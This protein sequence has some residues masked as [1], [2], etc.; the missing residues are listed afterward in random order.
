MNK[1]VVVTGSRK[2]FGFSL[3]REFAKKG[4]NVVMNSRNLKELNKSKKLIIDEYPKS[5]VICVQSDISQPKSCAKI[6]NNAIK[7]FGKIDYWINNAATLLYK[8]DDFYKLSESEISTI[9]NTNFTGMCYGTREAINAMSYHGGE[10]YNI[11]GSGSF[12]EVIDG[13]T[14]YS[15][16][17][18]PL[19]YFSK[20]AN[21]EAKHKNIHVHTINPGIIH[22]DLLHNNSN[23]PLFVKKYLT[24]TPEHIAEYVVA[25]IENRKNP[26]DIDFFSID[27]L[28]RT[29]LK[30]SLNPYEI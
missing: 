12:G 26:K 8:Y 1:T 29:V 23:I 6:A 3:S 15:S 21:L 13:Y 9:I 7:A 22:T 20:C 28:V 5:K 2:G 10:I 16:S 27:C 17:K 24:N 25:C 30:N 4:Y 19:V 11:K 14:M 18:L